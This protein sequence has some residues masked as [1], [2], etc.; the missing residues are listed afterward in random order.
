MARCLSHRSQFILADRRNTTDRSRAE[1]APR[2]WADTTRIQ[3]ADA[4][5]RTRG[6]MTISA[7]ERPVRQASAQPQAVTA[8]TMWTARLYQMA[9]SG[10]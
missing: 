3:E 8:R 9:A 5:P 1:R 2:P 10:V 7:C 4:Q 6:R